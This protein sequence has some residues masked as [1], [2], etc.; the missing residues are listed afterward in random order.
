M[1]T[2]ATAAPKLI[3]K[4]SNGKSCFLQFSVIVSSQ[5]ILQSF[6][7]GGTLSPWRFSAFCCWKKENFGI[8]WIMEVP[9]LSINNY[10][11]TGL[12]IKL[13][14]QSECGQCVCL[15]VCVC[16]SMR[17]SAW[18]LCSISIVSPF[19]RRGPLFKL[20]SQRPQKIIKN[21]VD[22]FNKYMDTVQHI[23]LLKYTKSMHASS[24]TGHYFLPI[25]MNRKASTVLHEIFED[26]K[27]FLV[28]EMES[29]HF[30]V[31][32]LIVKSPKNK[33]HQPNKIRLADGAIASCMK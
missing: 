23:I 15:F 30:L 26:N 7:A 27:I 2:P 8:A 28:A 31:P 13:R 32:P 20:G 1:E 19:I 6:S 4:W 10:V 33:N 25:K 11:W 5:I 18:K 12:S 21:M 16:E 14:F 29:L 24:C 17:L 3:R 22:S 9:F